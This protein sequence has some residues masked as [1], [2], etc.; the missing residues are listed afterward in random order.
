MV[1]TVDQEW[2]SQN[3]GPGQAM[4]I[5]AFNPS[6]REAEEAWGSH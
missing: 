1:I 5:H 3:I 2:I 4:V 6:N